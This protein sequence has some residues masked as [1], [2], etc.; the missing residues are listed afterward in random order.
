MFKSFFISRSQA[1]LNVLFFAHFTAFCRLP[2]LFNL[3]VKLI[4][5]RC[6]PG[7]LLIKLFDSG[8]DELIDAPIGPEQC[9]LANQRFQFRLERMVMSSLPFVFSSS[10][11]RGME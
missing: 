10:D 7:L 9:V 8:L 6:N 2:S 4:A 5:V 11:T 1:S 3:V